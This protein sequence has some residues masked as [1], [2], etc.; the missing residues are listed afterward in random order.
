MRPEIMRPSGPCSYSLQSPLAPGRVETVFADQA[1]QGL[2]ET[3]DKKLD[4][5]LE[6]V[7]SDDDESG[8]SVD[9]KRSVARTNLRMVR[10]VSPAGPRAGAA[11]RLQRDN[12]PLRHA[13]HRPESARLKIKADSKRKTGRGTRMESDEGLLPELVQ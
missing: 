10:R 5:T 11:D 1:Y 12:G 13:S 3:F 8:F 4:W 9:P 6:V 7:E 2:E